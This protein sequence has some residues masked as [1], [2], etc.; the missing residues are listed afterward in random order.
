M[1]AQHGIGKYAHDENK[2]LG[3][4]I[5]IHSNSFLYSRHM[6]EAGVNTESTAKIVPTAGRA[7]LAWSCPT[8]GTSQGCRCY[9]VC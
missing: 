2:Q 6:H 5:K 3:V 9:R 1:R 4:P 7:R 8:T